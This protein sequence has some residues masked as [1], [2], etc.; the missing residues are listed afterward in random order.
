MKTA[1]KTDFQPWEVLKLENL[2]VHFHT[3]PEVQYKFGKQFSN[4]RIYNN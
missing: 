3:L 1:F 2:H 4:K